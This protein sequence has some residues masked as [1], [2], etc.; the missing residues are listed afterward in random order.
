M[1]AVG[2]CPASKASISPSRSSDQDGKCGRAA[3]LGSR[4]ICRRDDFWWVRMPP[5]EWGAIVEW[6]SRELCRSSNVQGEGG[7]KRKE[8]TTLSTAA[9]DGVHK[10]SDTEK[11]SS[12][13]ALASPSKAML[14]H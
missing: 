10:R 9:Q 8:R 13:E 5:L 11:A 2:L 3:S 4:S 12:F 6:A 1:A 14:K 7:N